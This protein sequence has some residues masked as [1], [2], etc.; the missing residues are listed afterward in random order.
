MYNV[1]A[2]G[3]KASCF[4]S[5][6]WLLWQSP[7]QLQQEAEGS[8][9][10]RQ[11]VRQDLGGM[12]RRPRRADCRHFQHRAMPRGCTAHRGRPC[13]VPGRHGSQRFP[14]PFR[15]RVNR[16][17]GRSAYRQ[18]CLRR[19]VH[20]HRRRH[21]AQPSLEERWLDCRL[22]QQLLW[23]SQPPGRQRLYRHRCGQRAQPG[24]EERWL[25]CRLGQEHRFFCK[26]QLG[27]PS[28]TPGR[29]RLYRHRC[30][31]LPQSG[32]EGGWLGCRLGRQRGRPSHSPARQQLHRHR[33]RR[34]AQ[35]GPG[36]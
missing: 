23:T 19:P 4:V 24:P 21:M 15:P 18:E 33:R 5:N 30:R 34:F 1:L 2:A 13:P 22:G 29:Q 14:A 27:W 32:P 16:R 17:M 26:S 3:R 6:H 9:G 12:G 35:S 36:D 20:R 28:H 7:R 11:E 31:G 25:D 8:Y 10:Y